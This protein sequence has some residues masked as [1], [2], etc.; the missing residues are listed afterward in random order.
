MAAEWGP[1]HPRDALAAGAV[2]VKQYAWY[3]ALAGHW[4][5]GR[6]GGRCFDV[7]D[8]NVDQVYRPGSKIPAARHKAAVAESWAV[9]LRKVSRDRPDG[10]FFMPSYNGGDAYARCGAGVTGWKLWQHG[11]SA[12]ARQG[13]TFESI[14]RLYYGPDLRVVTRP[15]AARGFSAIGLFVDSNVAGIDGALVLSSDGRRVEA[16][17][18]KTLGRA[19]AGMLDHVITDLDGDG[20]PDLAALLPGPSGPRL[21]VFGATEKG[22]RGPRTLWARAAQGPRVPAEG[23]QLVAADWDGNGRPE[24]GLV[25]AVPGNAGSARLYEL[26]GD[27]DGSLEARAA[28]TGALDLAHATLFGGDFNGDGRGDL[29]AV[30]DRQ[31]DGI[32]LQVL[33]SEP[34]GG[35]FGS[36]ADWFGEPGLTNATARAV[37]GDVDGDGR[38]D[39]VLLSPNGD[40]GLTARL[41][42]GTPDSFT[43]S[44]LLTVED[45]FTWARIGAG[46]ADLDRDGRADLFV[47]S[48]PPD[49]SVIRTLYSRGASLARA[50]WGEDLHLS[51]AAGDA[52]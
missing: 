8:T 24:L 33:P 36:L 44:R 15:A 10:R 31:P 42:R 12:C 14:L 40:E 23:L 26:R 20:R 34:T 47:F 39:V 4:R 2:A 7:R 17:S 48:H 21:V 49:G 3:H 35:G 25:A 46:A 37:A 16:T 43:R 30:V 41:Y 9:S 6:L 27:A 5:G 1:S 38:D 18:D 29:A 51:W 45:G 52:Y 50:E 11:A 32:A 28:W 22:R 19:L 13:H